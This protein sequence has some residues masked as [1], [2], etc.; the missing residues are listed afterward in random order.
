M[1][2][3]LAPN[4]ALIVIPKGRVMACSLSDAELPI[5]TVQRYI[6]TLQAAGEWIE[7][8]T[9]NEAGSFNPAFPFCLAIT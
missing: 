6:T 4:G 1:K 7:Y 8:D 9:K 3:L 5:R 2:T